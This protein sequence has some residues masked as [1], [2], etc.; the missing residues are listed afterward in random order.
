[1]R[2]TQIEINLVKAVKQIGGKCWKLVSPGMRGVPDR[3]CLLPGG[4]AVFVETKAPGKRLEPLQEKRR[5]ELRA[6]GFKVY[7]ID[8][9]EQANEISTP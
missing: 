5:D 6:L 2:E 4:R 7:K 8:S 3:I 1:M 9:K